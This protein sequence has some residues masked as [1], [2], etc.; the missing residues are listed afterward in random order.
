MSERDGLA[1]RFEAER[2]Q[3]RRA[4]YRLLGS[5][6]EAEDAVQEAW[7]RLVRVD[8]EEVRNLGG[9][10]RTVV[11]R[12]CL[13]LLRARASRR[14]DLVGHELPD[15][16]LDGDPEQDAVL[17]DS[18]GRALLVV[19]NTLGPAERIAFVLHDMFAVPFDDIGS[20]V[21]RSAVATKKLASRARQKINGT[22]A[23]PT[24][25]LDRQRR[26]V[27]AFLAASRAGDVAA[28]VAVLAPDV[29]RRA[30]RAALSDGRPTEVRGARPVAEEIVV[31]GRNA[32]SAELALV[33]GAV[34]IVV[35]PLG[36]LL[37]AL[38]F[39]VESEQITGYQLI[40]DPDR[41]RGLDLALPYSWV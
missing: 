10:L 41:L 18:V 21:D 23:V 11:S 13:D 1:E 33:N 31:F 37:L 40:A 8:A 20:I 30:D 25:E 17:A 2:D 4:A 28:V 12:I 24:D 36:R 38:S 15:R 3:L 16:T 39:T 7:L 19:L 14:E 26:V 32:R 22:P 27:E 35:A 9:W 5:R 29:V 34:G 6:A